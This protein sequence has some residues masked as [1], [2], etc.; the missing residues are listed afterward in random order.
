MK[1]DRH[2]QAKILNSE[3]LERLFEVGLQTGSRSLPIRH[4][5][6]HR[7]PYSRDLHCTYTRELYSKKLS[8]GKATLKEN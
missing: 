1:I 3:G 7:L 2:G 8:S 5:S 6:L 4:L